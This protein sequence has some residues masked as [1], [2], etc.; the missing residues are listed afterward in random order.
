MDWRA[1]SG[2]H[3]RKN[4]IVEKIKGFGQSDSFTLF[5]LIFRELCSEANPSI[6]LHQSPSLPLS[7]S[8]FQSFR[9]PGGLLASTPFTTAVPRQPSRYPPLS[10]IIHRIFSA[11]CLSGPTARRTSSIH[12]SFHLCQTTVALTCFCCR[13]EP[14]DV[15]QASCSKGTIRT[16][17]WSFL[18]CQQQTIC[19]SITSVQG[20]KSIIFPCLPF[21]KRVN[22]K[23]GE[24][25]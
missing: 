18:H 10:E 15:N 25:L 17:S 14:A 24:L 4:A 21:V 12:L 13:K 1:E 22:M 19:Q 20:P 16:G 11:R 23:S 7:H 3:F 5:V 2:V 8:A 9:R 6:I